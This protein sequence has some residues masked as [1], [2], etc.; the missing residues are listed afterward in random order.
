MQSHAAAQAQAAAYHAQVRAFPF[1]LT[2]KHHDAALYQ[3]LRASF[4]HL[5]PGRPRLTPGAAGAAPGEPPADTALWLQDAPIAVRYRYEAPQL[6][7]AT[8]GD[9]AGRTAEAYARARV[10]PAS[11]GPGVERVAPAWLA[12]WGVEGAARAEYDL[13]APDAAG[14]DHE[15][16]LV[17][18]RA[19]GVML[20]TT[21]WPRGAVDAATLALFR[22]AA[23]ATLVW[24]A[25]RWQSASGLWPESS[26][27][28]P[29]VVATLWP[30]RE[31]QLAWLA[32]E[33]RFEDAEREA[34]TT[35]VDDVLRNAGAPWAGLDAAAWSAHR[36]RLLGALVQ[37]AARA[38]V[39]GAFGEVRTAQDLRGL[40]AMLGRAVSG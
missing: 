21:R 23:E 31:E 32:R 8:A 4:G 13:T 24:D 11:R 27:L 12:K 38:F 16:L 22:S 18:V 19:G 3:D 17:L 30:G 28:Q 34:V 6:A 26:F 40:A 39:E 37:P 10:A 25:R 36:D 2:P 15:E 20:V 9:L 35:A 14:A 7:A 29:R 1:A 5:L 33:A